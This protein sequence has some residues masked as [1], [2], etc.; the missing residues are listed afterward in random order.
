MSLPIKHQDYAEDAQ[1]IS[2]TELLKILS[3]LMT[4]SELDNES[5]RAM[6]DQLPHF[7]LFAV[8]ARSMLSELGYGDEIE[9][10]T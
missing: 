9:E 4:V 8:Q 5:S 1:S 3:T 2:A 10:T 6:K 7:G